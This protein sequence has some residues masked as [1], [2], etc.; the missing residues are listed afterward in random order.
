MSNPCFSIKK[1]YSSGE[2]SQ[3]IEHTGKRYRDNKITSIALLILAVLF[4]MASFVFWGIG[5][6]P[7]SVFVGMGVLY[8]L[9]GT[10][11]SM[12]SLTLFL[13]C[14]AFALVAGVRAYQN[15]RLQQQL[16]K[17]ED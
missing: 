12:V 9:A 13:G 11:L 14:L 15:A 5:A 6:L 17:L 16:V 7:P 1:E 2:I 4:L 3:N 10:T 8:S